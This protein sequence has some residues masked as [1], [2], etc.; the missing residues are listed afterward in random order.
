MLGSITRTTAANR[1]EPAMN[2][3]NPSKA[4]FAAL[5]AELD[6]QRRQI[7]A[8]SARRAP[9]RGRNL[10]A[11]LGICF[12]LVL[13]TAA[14]AAIPGA[15][16]VIN[17]CFLPKSGILRLIDAEAGER[18]TRKEQ[19]IS[20]N[21]TGP[22]GLPGERGL[23]GEPGP[24]GVQGLPGAPGAQGER[25]PQGEP[26]PQGVQGLQGPQGVPG[27]PG[28]SGL[29]IVWAETAI[30]SSTEKQLFI[31]CPAGKRA[32]SAGVEVRT[33]I[34]REGEPIA[35]HAVLIR[36]DG[37]YVKAIETAPYAE[38]WFLDGNVVCA[39]VAP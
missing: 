15:G 23:Q 32:I 9:L 25:G 1:K 11:V 37:A 4:T 34:D 18:C 30:D 33:R 8:L 21:Q 19:A 35:V 26:G 20:W 29:E 5:Q 22:Q 27:T 39:N 24:Q 13:S 12:A 10:G 31:P 17:A 3:I 14:V 16:G 2:P 28:I 6:A 36:F 7:A 38:N